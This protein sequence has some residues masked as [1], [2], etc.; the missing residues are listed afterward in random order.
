MRSELYL[1]VPAQTTKAYSSSE[2]HKVEY[3]F[4]K[5]TGESYAIYDK[6]YHKR[7]GHIV[8]NI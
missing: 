7:E 3:I 6:Q 5:A 4:R 2:R 8:S 1:H